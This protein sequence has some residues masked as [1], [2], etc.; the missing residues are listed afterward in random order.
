MKAAFSKKWRIWLVLLA[1]AGLL[2]ALLVRLSMLQVVDVD[3]GITFLQG[4]GDARTVRAETVIANRG[5]ITDRNGQPLAVSTPVVTLWANP[6]EMQISA[7]QLVDLARLLDTPVK[8][9]KERLALYNGKQFMYLRRQMSP[10]QAE[11]VLELKIRGIYADKE[12]RRFYPAGEVT[13]HILGFTNIENRGQEGLELA[14]NQWLEGHNGS[15]RVVKDLYQRTIKTLNTVE[16]A[17]PGKDITLS[18]DLRIQHHAYRILKETVTKH[19]ADAG[20]AVVLDV[21][22]GEILAM[23]N[24]PAFNPNNRNTIKPG[25]VRNR[26]VT[27]VFEPGSTVKTFT[28][29]AALESGKYKPTTI[30]DT[31]PGHIRVNGKTLLDPVNYHQLDLTGVL[32][33]SSQVGTTKIAL[34]LEH[35]AIYQTFVRLGLGDYTGVGF[36]G[37]STGVLPMKRRWSDIERANFAFGYGLSVTALQLA[38]AYAVFA[39]GGIKKPVTLLKKND[40]ADDGV[41]IIDERLALQVNNMLAEVT[42]PK[43]TAK[44]AQLDMYSVAGK[45]GTSHKV[46]ARGYEAGK[47]MSFFAGF[48]PAKNPRIVA[49]VVVDDPKGSQYYGGEVAAPAFASIA[50]GSLRML[51]VIPDKLL[52]KQQLAQVGR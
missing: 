1:L 41:R 27:D 35:E 28:M 23:V 24:Q 49:V 20:T 30:V 50:A 17:R 47:Y 34:S 40:A 48:A 18:I 16:E 6:K 38:Q 15:N 21:E 22:T 9:L 45:T 39:N 44:T 10:Q 29:L 5:M 7:E 33:K 31:H 51:N 11:E 43:G 2:L 36:P 12:L 32:V 42:G 37:E 52:E 4:Q 8:E 13:S 14:Y 26:A 3:G 19:R 46:G 25:T